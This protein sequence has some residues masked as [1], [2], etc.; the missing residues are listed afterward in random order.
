MG[1]H[2]LC[3]INS[4]VNVSFNRSFLSSR[5]S[6]RKRRHRPITLSLTD[7]FKAY[8]ITPL[9]QNETT[10][11]RSFQPRRRQHIPD[12]LFPFIPFTIK[13]L[14]VD[15]GSLLTR[16]FCEWGTS[17]KQST[18][19]EASR[20]ALGQQGP[21]G[22]ISSLNSSSVKCS[23]VSITFFRGRCIKAFPVCI[24]TRNVKVALCQKIY[25]A[26]NL[27]QIMHET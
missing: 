27:I 26:S 16:I 8:T 23:Q 4:Q 5:L 11:N 9:N 15:T 7:M 6:Q 20:P 2:F 24:R 3:L 13:A 18:A 19:A 22:N 12:T 21:D 14:D 10:L 25:W 17:M 1:G